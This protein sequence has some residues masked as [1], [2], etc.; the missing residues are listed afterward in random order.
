[1]GGWWGR[2]E[3]GGL[4]FGKHH[5]GNAA[6]LLR[7]IAQERRALQEIRLRHNRFGL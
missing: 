4:H 7:R 6:Q 3:D 1:M 2:W 5:V